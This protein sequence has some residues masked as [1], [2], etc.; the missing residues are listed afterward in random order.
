[1]YSYSL[2]LAH[3]KA[4]H[5][6]NSSELHC[7]VQSREIKSGGENLDH[8][9]W[10]HCWNVALSELEGKRSLGHTVLLA[11]TIRQ[12]VLIAWKVSLRLRCIWKTGELLAIKNRKVII[13]EVSTSVALGAHRRAEE[14]QVLSQRR[15]KNNHGS[16]GIAS[17]VEH[18]VIGI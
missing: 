18:P 12:K 10:E 14:D 3:E 16:H 17:I 4:L 2:Q 9:K 6:L 5:D 8:A 1:M 7:F 11:H 13:G 15:M